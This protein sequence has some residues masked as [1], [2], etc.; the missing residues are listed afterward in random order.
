MLYEYIS[1]EDHYRLNGDRHL[2]RAKMHIADG[3]IDYAIGS[4][5]KAKKNYDVCYRLKA[6]EEAMPIEL[7]REI[8]RMAQSIANEI[9][10]GS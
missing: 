1:F 6:M 8:D 7:R 2:S 10:N 5:K 9:M 4:L 3:K